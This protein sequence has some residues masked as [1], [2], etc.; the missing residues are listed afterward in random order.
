MKPISS[1]LCLGF[2]FD[3]SP[4]IFCGFAT[5]FQL[6]SPMTCHCGKI[7]EHYLGPVTSLLVS[8]EWTSSGILLAV[9]L[10]L[11]MLPLQMETLFEQREH[12]NALVTAA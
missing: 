2:S 9:S 10:S 8:K 6:C 5:I 1:Q 3:T 7:Q 11:P 12:G 4:L